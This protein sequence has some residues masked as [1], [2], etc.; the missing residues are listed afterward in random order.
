MKPI[1]I[2]EDMK[3]S[4]A[5]TTLMNVLVSP[6]LYQQADGSPVSVWGN[7]EL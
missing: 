4:D 6:L 2:I 3:L 7:L 5:P 1:F